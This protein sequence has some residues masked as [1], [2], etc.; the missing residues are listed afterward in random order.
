MTTNDEAKAAL[1]DAMNLLAE[2]GWCQDKLHD[3]WGRHCA[4]GALAKAT[5]ADGELSMT[6]RP[7]YLGAF[8]RLKR[9]VDDE[10]GSVAIWNDTPGRTIEDVLLA[11]KQAI[12]EEGDPK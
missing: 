4:M 10:N 2:D 7:H 3:Q 11:F 9:V 1:E 8:Y 12:G 6:E 5:R